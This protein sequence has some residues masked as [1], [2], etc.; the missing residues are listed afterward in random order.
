[1]SY[2][3]EKAF[4][5]Y[6]DEV[7][8]AKPSKDWEKQRNEFLFKLKEHCPPCLKLNPQLLILKLQENK[9]VC[10]AIIFNRD[11]SKLLVIKV[12]DKLGFP[13]GKWNQQEPAEACAAR[14]VQEETGISI[15]GKIDDR[16]RIEFETHGNTTYFFVAKGVSEA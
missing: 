10:G 9:P 6:V 14:E 15:T 13:K 7:L 3:A 4:Y 2:H 16:I 11:S 1:L 8:R 12:K 5:Y